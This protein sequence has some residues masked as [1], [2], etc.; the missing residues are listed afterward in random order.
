M[1]DKFAIF[2]N[3]VAQSKSPPIHQQFADQFG[4][5]IDYTRIFSTDEQFV[6]DLKQFFI[7]G[8]VGCN[9][10]AP[11]KELAFQSCD[12]LTDKAARARAVN[13][14][15]KQPDNTLLGHNS[16]GVGLVTD[17]VRNKQVP[18]RDRHIMILGAGGAT[19]GILEPII[20]E[21]PGRI[22]LANRTVARAES[23]AAEFADIYT[24]QVTS[25][26]SPEYESA[27]DL[28]INATSA[29]LSSN[30]PV[31]DTSVIAE[32]T[33]CYDLS[34]AAQPTSF[35]QWAKAQGAARCIDGKG[36][37]VEQAANSFHVWTGHEPQ[38]GNVIEWLEQ[39]C[40]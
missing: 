4:L 2:G 3:P 23:L 19:R 37:L 25:T 32:N 5:Q 21:Q 26:D 40:G 16:D 28:L 34:Y 7:G 27:P 11:F 13:T 9:V 22:T 10:T 39:N 30:V 14:V 8:A 12:T 15:F 17:I 35:L 6:D 38:T 20:A 1:T 33:V 36:M 18:M 31:K 24:M 29:S